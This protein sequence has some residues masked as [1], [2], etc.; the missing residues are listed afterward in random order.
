M[1]GETRGRLKEV[2]FSDPYLRVKIEVLQ[3]SEQDVPEDVN[4]E[5]ME[6]ALLTSKCTT[7]PGMIV[8]PLKGTMGRLF[9]SLSIHFPPYL[10]KCFSP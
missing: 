6:R 10:V 2:D 9:I 5:A 7:I 4:A 8:I 3:D 1:S